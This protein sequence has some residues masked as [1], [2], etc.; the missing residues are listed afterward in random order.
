MS[1]SISHHGI[2][3]SFITVS[4]GLEPMEASRA[5]EIPTRGAVGRWPR[6][7]C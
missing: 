4:L 3:S 7:T 6:A 5:V 2:D 1:R